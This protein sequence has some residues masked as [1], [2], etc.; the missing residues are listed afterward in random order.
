MPN[1]KCTFPGFVQDFGNTQKGEL[2]VLAEIEDGIFPQEEQVSEG[3]KAFI[4]ADVV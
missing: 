4:V 2:T 1:S 3:P